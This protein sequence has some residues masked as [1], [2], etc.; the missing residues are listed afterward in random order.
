MTNVM[1]PKPLAA[2]RERAMTFVE[3]CAKAGK[4]SVDV[5]VS[6]FIDFH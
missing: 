1:K 5:Y 3:Q 6:I 2:I 4:T